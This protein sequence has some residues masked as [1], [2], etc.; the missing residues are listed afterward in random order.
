[1]YWK[2]VQDYSTDLRNPAVVINQFRTRG[3]IPVHLT[4][5]RS[6]RAE[7]VHYSCRITLSFVTN[8][9]TLPQSHVF[10]P[11]AD[12]RDQPRTD[13]DQFPP[14][15]LLHPVV[16]KHRHL[17]LDHLHPLSPPGILELQHLR[18]H[19]APPP[20]QAAAHAERR[21]PTQ[22]DAGVDQCHAWRCAEQR[23]QSGAHA[24]AGAGERIQCGVSASFD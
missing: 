21:Q 7:L 4:L 19:S 6:T 20:S 17:R 9:T 5:L 22:I 1:M 8:H 13:S 24:G 16:Q 15:L 10:F 14:Q 23:Q 11:F 2:P 3:Y 18:R 12:K